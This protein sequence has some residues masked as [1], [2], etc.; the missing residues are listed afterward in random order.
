MLC[1]LL[2]CQPGVPPS[3][4][5]ESHS[6]PLSGP[7]T[8][9]SKLPLVQIKL[10]EITPADLKAEIEKHKGKVVL[11]DFWALWCPMCLESFHHLSEWYL[12]YSEKGLVII[13]IN[14]DENSPETRKKVIDYLQKQRAPFETFIS[15]KG[16]TEGTMQ[17]F[18]IDGDS[19]PYCQIYNRE[20]AHVISLG[21]VNPDQI[22]DEPSISKALEKQF[23]HRQ[24]P[25]SGR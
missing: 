23:S 12:K 11:V 20:G 13:T 3:A 16:S 19:L 4:P 8:T 2:S 24:S 6:K 18:K 1:F 17:A 5:D 14:L 9:I 7:E 15:L 25:V 21:N 10:H 22:Y